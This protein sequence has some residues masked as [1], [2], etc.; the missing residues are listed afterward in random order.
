MIDL[1][2]LMKSDRKF[3]KI[4]ESTCKNHR[5]LYFQI[6]EGDEGIPPHFHPYGEDHAFILEGELTYDISFEQQIV[7]KKNSLVFG[8]TYAVHG[9]H[10][11]NSSSLHILVFAT[12]EHNSSVYNESKL[13]RK[14]DVKLRFIEALP[15]KDILFSDRVI[16]SSAPL[17]CTNTLILDTNRQILHVT[18][19]NEPC[20]NPLFFT[21]KSP[22]S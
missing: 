17:D 3:E 12:P 21:F 11:T 15:I 16:F 5:V 7:A 4:W 1:V 18:L 13:P 19:C 6:D 22:I 9:Y 2:D 14:I 8:W 10:N 20:G